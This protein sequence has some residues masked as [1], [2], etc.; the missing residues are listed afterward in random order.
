MTGVQTIKGDSNLISANI[1]KGKTIFGV[2][3]NGA[4]VREYKVTGVKYAGTKTFKGYNHLSGTFIYRDARL[5]YTNVPALDFTPVWAICSTW[6]S[7]YISECACSFYWGMHYFKGY[8]SYNGA[9]YRGEILENPINK[10]GFSMPI[11]SSNIT[12]GAVW[13]FGY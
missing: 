2:V 11:V 12:G 13:V 5:P 7:R 8:G 4:G 10:S 6:D 1:L 9:D 3:G